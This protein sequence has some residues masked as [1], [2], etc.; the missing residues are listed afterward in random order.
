MQH[1][2][3]LIVLL[4]FI[5]VLVNVELNNLFGTIGIASY[6]GPRFHGRETANGEIF[7]M[8]QL[9]AAHRRLAFN[10]NIKVTNLLNYKSV[11]VR[12][13][14]RG[15]YIS[16]RIID[17]SMEAGRRIGMIRRG[18]VPVTIKVVQ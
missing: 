5:A 11:T 12:I 6:Y 8:N 3:I 4:V 18:I 16:G 2:R 9:T 1:R 15:P 13:N 17:L 14:D 10:T 7:D